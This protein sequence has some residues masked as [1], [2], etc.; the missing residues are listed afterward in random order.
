MKL[1][2]RMQNVKNKKVF[3]RIDPISLA[4]VV[5]LGASAVFAGVQLYVN[6]SSEDL[7]VQ[8]PANG[9]NSDLIYTDNGDLQTM[10]NTSDALEVA[11]LGETVTSPLGSEDIEVTKYYYSDTVGTDVQTQSFFYYPVGQS[12]YSHESKGMSFKSSND[13]VVNVVAS[14]TGTV[15][16]VK[17][18]ILKG[19]IVTIEHAN[20]VETVYTGVYDVKVNVGDEVS[21]GTVIGTTGLSQLEPEAGNVVHFEIVKD[22]VKIDPQ[23]AIDKK[24]SDL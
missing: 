9:N 17:D 1:K 22:E 7:T 21:Q 11:A 23:S 18:E 13:E 2:E 3:K 8:N 12:M 6:Q 15:S 19:T 16:S 10:N 24:L 14:L 20:G 4:L 5:L